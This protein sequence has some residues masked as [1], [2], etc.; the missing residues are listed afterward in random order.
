MDAWT[1]IVIIAVVLIVLG[2]IVKIGALS[3][4]WSGVTAITQLAVSRPL[5]AIAILA[6]VIVSF[7]V[8][9]VFS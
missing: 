8:T 7:V 3:R 5:V 1:S 9:Q 6:L 4:A 2:A